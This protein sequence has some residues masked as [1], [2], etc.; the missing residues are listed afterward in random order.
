MM[1]KRVKSCPSTSTTSQ[2]STAP[3]RPSTQLHFANPPNTTSSRPPAV[4]TGTAQ[5]SSPSECITIIPSRKSIDCKSLVLPHC[6]FA[7][8]PQR[9][10]WHQLSKGST[11]SNSSAL[12]M[13]ASLRWTHTVAIINPNRAISTKKTVRKAPTP[14]SASIYS[15]EDKSTY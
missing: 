6:G 7:S 13:D 14:T 15:L 1:I 11:T 5:L 4:P 9:N 8:T 12:R 2:S 10:C 3:P